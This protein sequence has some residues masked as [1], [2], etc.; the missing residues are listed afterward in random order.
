MTCGPG[1]IQVDAVIK[2]RTAHAGIAPETGISAIQVAA[3]AIAKMNLLRIDEETTCNIGTIKAEFA[4]NIV[5]DKCEIHAE[6]RSRNLDK[7]NA[8]AAHIK[9]CL[10][11]TCAEMGAEIDVALTTNYVSFA[12]AE[13]DELVKMVEN[14][15]GDLGLNFST[16]K[17]GG[18]SDANVMAFHGFKSVVLGTGMTKVHTTDECLKVE[19]LNKTSELVLYLLTH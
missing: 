19:D 10:E 12:V 2:G 3:K 14:A 8:Q 16:V 7:L 15:C 9:E 5:P 17:G 1:Q 6:V 11:S 13:D 4:T 18:G